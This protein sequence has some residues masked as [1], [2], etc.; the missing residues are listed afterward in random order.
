VANSWRIE[1]EL[2]RHGAEAALDAFE[3]L[4][5]TDRS[6]ARYALR[7]RLAGRGVPAAVANQG[8]RAAEQNLASWQDVADP[9]VVVRARAQLARTLAV[10][11]ERERALSEVIWVLDQD[12]MGKDALIGWSAVNQVLIASLMLGETAPAVRATESLL[13]HPSFRSTQRLLLDPTYRLLWDV[14]EFQALIER[15]DAVGGG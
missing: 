12:P 6:S 3:S 2:L 13:A 10:A 8:I 11:G 9:F 5:P 14:P 15:Y 1:R 4:F 7:L